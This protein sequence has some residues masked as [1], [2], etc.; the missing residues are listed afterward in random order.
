MTQWVPVAWMSQ[1]T[2]PA[3]TTKLGTFRSDSEYDYQYEISY[4]W[5]MHMRDDRDTVT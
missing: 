2:Q 4:Y 3:Q 5:A 1:M